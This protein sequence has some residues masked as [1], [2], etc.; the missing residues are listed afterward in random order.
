MNADV[1]FKRSCEL[2]SFIPSQQPLIKTYGFPFY[3]ELALS[4]M[5]QQRNLLYLT[6]IE[7]QNNPDVILNE[8]ELHIQDIIT[9]RKTP[10]S[11]EIRT[12][13]DDSFGRCD[14]AFRK[15]IQSVDKDDDND[16]INRYYREYQNERNLLNTNI[17][18]KHEDEYRQILILN[19]DKKLWQKID[20]SG[21]IKNEPSKTHINIEN[22]RD[23]FETL[24]QPLPGEDND[25]LEHLTSELYIPVNDDH[26]STEELSS[27]AA[28]MR[29]GGWDYSLTVL[30]LLIRG[31]PS[32]LLMLLNAMF[33][34]AYPLKPTLSML[35]AIP[36]T[37][38][39]MCSNNYRGIQVQPLLGTLY[40]RILA[41]RLTAWSSISDE[42]SVFQKGKGTLNRIFTLRLLIALA[43][44]Y[45]KSLYLGFFDLSKA[46]TKSHV[47]C[48]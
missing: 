42:Q 19:D 23:H 10:K 4:D 43:T 12:N 24:Y 20:W 28:S 2:K 41:S 37:G 22:L 27:A 38:N 26:I 14:L 11:S 35:T 33:F 15:Y 48:S 21:N 13:V 31:I 17:L 7:N 16:D 39:L 25:A 47:C 44:K 8:I 40:D 46:L 45:N 9:S 29:K 3:E 6:C 36:K 18:R 34:Y 5:L 32:C 1:I 30:M